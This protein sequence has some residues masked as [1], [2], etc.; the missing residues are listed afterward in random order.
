[1]G[2]IF[3]ALLG[4]V[5]AGNV[6]ARIG[7]RNRGSCFGWRLTGH[8]R[9]VPGMKDVGLASELLKPCNAGIMRSY[10]V[11]TRLNQ[12]V[13]DDEECSVPVQLVQTQSQLLF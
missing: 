8:R 9:R 12:V 4:A 2:K 3:N 7:V 1:L 10:P 6:H 13:N 11:S 5:A